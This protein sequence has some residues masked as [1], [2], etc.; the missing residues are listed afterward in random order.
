MIFDK[1]FFVSQ[2][3]SLE[4]LGKIKKSIKRNLELA[5]SSNEPEIIFHFSY[6]ALIK[7]G[8]YY[9]AREGY[10]VKSQPGHHIKIIE[11]LG[12]ILDSE[13]ILITGDKMRKDRNLDLYGVDSA[14]EQEEANEYL[15]F[16][17]GLFQ[18]MK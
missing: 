7:I 1:N 13:D 8:I 6:M 12:K 2:K 5:R 14:I 4:E 15:E 11:S 17:K 9:I 16:V 10:R 3:F 18:K